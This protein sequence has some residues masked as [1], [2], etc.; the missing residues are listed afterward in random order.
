MSIYKYKSVDNIQDLE[1]TLDIIKNNRLYLPNRNQLND[2]LEG[3]TDMDFGFAGCRYYSETPFLHPHYDAELSKIR[4]LSLTKKADSIIMWSH[5]A[6]M[7]NGVCIE[8]DD[9]ITLSNVKPIEYCDNLIIPKNREYTMEE[10]AKEALF[11]KSKE[12][13][14]EEEYRIISDSEYLKLEKGEIRRIYIG[15]MVPDNIMKILVDECEMKRIDTK[16]SY[17]NPYNC[18]VVS[19]DYDEYINLINQFPDRI[20]E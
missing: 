6:G 19:L 11:H 17:V 13:Q 18:K 12:W 1:H 20:C 15:Y 16:I 9:S 8:F 14:Y 4:V 5:Y 10:T 7:F 3:V 2:P